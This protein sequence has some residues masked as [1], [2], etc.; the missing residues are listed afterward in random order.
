LTI[1]AYPNPSTDHLVLK[2]YESEIYELTYQLFDINGKLLE[3]N[4][5]EGNLST[6]TLRRYAPSVYFLKVMLGDR[7][8]KTFKIVKH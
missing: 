6:I 8:V 5:V 7:D 2:I 1:S 4:K 3:V